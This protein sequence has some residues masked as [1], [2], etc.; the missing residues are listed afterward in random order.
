MYRSDSTNDQRNRVI[1]T[2]FVQVQG[3]LVGL[4]LGAGCLPGQPQG[5]QN[6]QAIEY[7]NQDNKT[8]HIPSDK[9]FKADNARQPENLYRR[10]THGFKYRGE[11]FARNCHFC[12]VFPCFSNGKTALR[13]MGLCYRTTR[14][15]RYSELA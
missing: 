12:W 7:C 10:V 14:V 1:M 6:I 9:R 2:V 8:W 11:V 3:I 13:F 4:A 5:F 15:I